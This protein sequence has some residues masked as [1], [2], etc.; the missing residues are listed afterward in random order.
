MKSCLLGSV[1]LGLMTCVVVPP[2][3]F[4]DDVDDDGDDGSWQALISICAIDDFLPSIS[5]ILRRP[6]MATSEAAAAA[7]EA[8]FASE[9]AC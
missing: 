8:D 2:L 5:F 3:T 7:D 4:A 6:A 1:V 9:E